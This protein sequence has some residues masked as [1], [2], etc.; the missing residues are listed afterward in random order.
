MLNLLATEHFG[1]DLN[2]VTIRATPAGR[3]VAGAMRVQAV[4][5]GASPTPP[6][7]SDHDVSD[8]GVT[9]LEVVV[10]TLGAVALVAAA[11]AMFSRRRRSGST[12]ATTALSIG[13]ILDR[14]K[15]VVRPLL[16]R[17]LG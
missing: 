9:L 16:Q 3:L 14:L 2:S 5:M 1:G 12:D 6:E 8:P 17:V 13:P 7:W 4:R 11:T 10:Y 15:A